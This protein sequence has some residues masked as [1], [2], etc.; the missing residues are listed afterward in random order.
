MYEYI[1]H[2][3]TLG[4]CS[5]AKECI[6]WAPAS[7]PIDKK[8]SVLTPHHSSLH[9]M[10]LA[11]HASEYSADIS[12]TFWNKLKMPFVKFTWPILFFPDM[13]VP[14]CSHTTHMIAWLASFHL[15]QSIC[16][17]FYSFYFWKQR[18]RCVRRTLWKG[19]QTHAHTSSQVNCLRT[20]RNPFSNPAENSTQ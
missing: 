20:H 9:T 4:G 7:L 6:E 17:H 12:L 19:S 10:V 8:Y 2:T 3:H 18:N 1:P 11:R 14:V 16:D 13:P 5:E 15:P